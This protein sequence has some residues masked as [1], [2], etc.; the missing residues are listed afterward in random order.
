MIG[1]DRR[2]RHLAVVP[3][4]TDAPETDAPLPDAPE[5]DVSLPE[6]SLQAVP[7]TAGLVPD[8]PDQDATDPTGPT[9]DA[10]IL[11]SGVG[12][13]YGRR[14]ALQGCSLNIPRGSVVAVVGRNGAGK[15]TLLQL[16]AGLLRPDAGS[17][18]VLGQP[19]WPPRSGWLTQVGFVAQDKALYPGL[20]VADLLRFGRRNNPGW[21]Q[22][23][24]QRRLRERGVPLGARIG[25]LSGGLRTQVALA[26][27]LAKR[28]EVLLLDEPLADLD[29]LAR[30]EVMSSLMVDLM[31]R[32]TTVLFSSHS[33]TDL[34]RV[35]DWL[36]LIDGGQVR[37]AD[38][39][40]ALV[41]RHR[42]LIGPVESATRIADR[43]A[44]VSAHRG[45]RQAILLVD[46]HDPAVELD[47]HWTVR[48]PAV[49]DLV[50]G[51]LQ[52][53]P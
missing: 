39:I 47:P 23:F 9:Q 4:E 18:T 52:Q 3:P 48:Q 28:P 11:T 38:S 8:T 24:A 19:T 49:E 13:R 10:A 44:V 22:E 12:I 29:P 41:A 36:V 16:L 5:T 20:R 46:G 32:N 21:D 27:A 30:R 51:Y 25:K 50:F 17:V 43:V 40:D 1:P 37:L 15:S 34:A 33:L 35:C 31:E 45:D 7:Q 6:A 14:W 42:L 2:R 26:L 53:V